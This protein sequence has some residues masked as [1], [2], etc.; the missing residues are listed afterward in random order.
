MTP[1][2]ELYRNM[3]GCVICTKMIDKYEFNLGWLNV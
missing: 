3:H 1:V 2:V